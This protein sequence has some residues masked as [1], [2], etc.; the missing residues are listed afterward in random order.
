MATS[1]RTKIA[2]QVSR[3]SD[4]SLNSFNVVQ[5][6]PPKKEQG[7]TVEGEKE[8]VVVD[9]MTSLD[10]QY[11]DSFLAAVERNQI[12]ISRN[13]MI[14]LYSLNMLSSNS[15][16]IRFT[17]KFIYL[18]NKVGINSSG[19]SIYDI[20]ID[21]VYFV[22]NWV[23]TVTF[24]RSFLIKY[25][26]EPFASRFCH[27][28]SRKAKT[29]FA[30]QSWSFLYWGVSFIFG[31]YLYLDAPYFNDL[32]QIYINWP[33]FYMDAKFKSYYLISMAFWFQQILVLHVEKPRKDHYQMFSHHIITCLLIVG[34]YYYYYF[35]I[36]H[37]I[38]MIMDSVDIFLAAAKMLKYAKFNNAC[39]AM[40]IL[41]LVSWIGLRHGVYN[42]I[43]YHAWDK[44]VHLMSDGQ[45]IEGAVQ[46]RCW[47]PTVINTFLGLLGGLQVI[48]C[49]WMY[50]ISKVAYRVVIGSG[51]EDVRSDEDDT[52]VEAEDNV[53]NDTDVENE[54]EDKDENK[55][56]N[57]DK[58]KDEDDRNSRFSTN[59]QDN[60][61]KCDVDEKSMVYSSVMEIT[62]NDAK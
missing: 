12:P 35:R 58:D 44:S 25:C 50:L 18:Q 27:I 49:I 26:F 32:D 28:Y 3:R 37:L 54:V 5:S 2:S 45:C 24:L 17:S 53:E 16:I 9:E 33:N 46:K 4:K 11:H 29:R 14:L 36:G 51:A 30:E 21:D 61:N 41:F 1:T 52:D 47:T 42:Y 15:N 48:T 55:D 59:T 60:A 8:D 7:T 43:F 57:M 10:Q 20:S 19:S 31:V 39:D 23:V 22:I 38:L 40:F 34:S 62:L 6:K 13:L 56:E